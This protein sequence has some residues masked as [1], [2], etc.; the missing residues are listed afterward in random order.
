MIEANAPTEYKLLVLECSDLMR[1]ILNFLGPKHI[2]K[3]FRICKYWQPNSTRCLSDFNT[4][5]IIKVVD[6]Q[7][8]ENLVGFINWMTERISE[9]NQI[10]T[11]SLSTDQELYSNIESIQIN[12]DSIGSMRAFFEAD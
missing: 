6:F 3:S 12:L 10:K 7:T 11:G 1:I 4:H 9:S 8:P 5:V 2:S